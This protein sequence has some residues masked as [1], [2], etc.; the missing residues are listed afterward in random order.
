MALALIPVDLL[1]LA[2][3]WASPLEA[4]GERVIQWTPIPVATF[5]LLNLHGQAVHAAFLGATA[6]AL[7]LG[8]LAGVAVGITSAAGIRIML[9]GVVFL[10]INAL[11]FPPLDWRPLLFLTCVYGLVAAL[12]FGI[13]IAV[14]GR[15]LVASDRSRQRFLR[16]FFLVVAAAAVL[17][18]T[19]DLASL[20]LSAPGRRLFRFEPH[21][22]RLRLVT[23]VD[24][25]YVNSKNLLAPAPRPLSIAISGR[26]KRPLTMDAAA[27]ER[28]PQIRHYST[29]ECVDNPVGGPLIGTALWSGV[30]LHDVLLLVDPHQDAT[31]LVVHGADG[32]DQSIPLD[33]A[34]DPDVLLATGMNGS[35]LSRDHGYPVRLVVPGR[36]GFKSVKWVT[37]LTLGSELERG[38]WQ[39]LGWTE[40]ATVR[41]TTRIDRVILRGGRAIVSGMAFAGNRGIRGV[42]LRVNGDHWANA[43]LIGPVLSKDAWR[44]WQGSV[45]VS[46]HVHIEARAIDGLGHL[47]AGAARGVYPSGAGGYASWSGRV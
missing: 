24:A 1:C 18:A 30:R 32:F 38:L 9:P 29:M 41:T 35:T 27:L 44:V 36:Y 13:P 17:A 11:F 12:I 47:Q 3:G 6:L 19:P 8:G 14:H 5:L 31:A 16:E 43:T 42:Q 34:G 21:G 7:V 23:A 45:T 40:D 4:L 25:F 20:M 15:D 39:R 10:G 33:L 28:L 37:G 26:V 46:G 2:M 22:D